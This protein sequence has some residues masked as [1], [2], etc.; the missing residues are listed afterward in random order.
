L[1]PDPTIWKSLLR[2]GVPLAAASIPVTL[3]LRFDQMLMA[4]WLPAK[5]LGYYVV[6]VS[7]SGAVAPLLTAVAAALFP[8][9]AAIDSLAGKA[10]ALGRIVRT[11]LL[12]AAAAGLAVAVATPIA[13]PLLFGKA[14][15]PSV[16]PAV[17]LVLAGCLSGLNVVLEQGMQGL[18][19]SATILW[20]ELGG[21]LVTGASLYWL[22]PTWGIIGAALASILAYGT[23][24]TLLLFQMKKK[25]ARPLTF[26]VIPKLDDIR[27]VYL[28][29]RAR[30]KG[31]FA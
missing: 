31:A 11:S 26:F 4:V 22:L 27:P 18:G 20:C 16:R 6:G 2:Y 30:L 17:I 1:R 29:C 13:I 9:I 12:L 21:F 24:C 8:K 23:I 7:W 15:L 14:F 19:E 10:D 3:N 28:Y 5:Q 25:T